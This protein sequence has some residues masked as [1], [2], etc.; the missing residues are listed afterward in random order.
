[1]KSTPLIRDIMI[2]DP[3]TIHQRIYSRSIICIFFVFRPC[4]TM[5]IRMNKGRTLWFSG[6]VWVFSSRFSFYFL[7]IE[8]QRIFFTVWEPKYFF[9]RTKQKQIFFSKQHK[10]S[11]CIILYFG[12]FLE[13]KIHGY[14]V[15]T[16]VY[17]L[18]IGSECICTY[19]N[20][21]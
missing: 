18:D 21:F 20:L 19:Q 12:V 16:F 11:K 14:I 13:P 6:G 1:M 17:N 4:S 15:Y 10:C 7:P 8:N 3:S 9:F 2:F 5:N